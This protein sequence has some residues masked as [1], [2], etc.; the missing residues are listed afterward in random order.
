MRRTRKLTE[1]G[2]IVKTELYKKGMT[3]REL[4]REIGMTEGTFCD[5]LAGRNKNPLHQKNI[6]K[7]L[8]LKVG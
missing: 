2:L 7:A 1:F 8:E 3:N 6:S 4:A 5:V